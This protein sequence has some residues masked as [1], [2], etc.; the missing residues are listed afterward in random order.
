MDQI[1]KLITEFTEMEKMLMEQRTSE[2]N[3]SAIFVKKIA[4]YGTLFAVFLG[5]IIFFFLIRLVAKRMK[6]LMQ[7]ISSITG[8]D[9]EIE[10][11]NS[12]KDEFA[13]AL[14]NLK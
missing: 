1:R 9:L 3:D 2:A 7:S 4:I 8:G 11:D 10:I 5:I 6:L 13:E 12:G 14:S